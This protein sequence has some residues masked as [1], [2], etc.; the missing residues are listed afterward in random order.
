MKRDNLVFTLCGFL[1]G[2]VLGSFIIGPHLAQKKDESATMAA[3]IAPASS[4]PSPSA[5][6]AQPQGNAMEMVRQQIATLKQTIERNP[7]DADALV[8]LGNIYMDAAKY[9]QAIDYYE[10]SL[11]VREDGNVRTD[12][13]I[14][15]KQ[16]GDLAKSLAAFQK[17]AEDAPGQWQALFNEAIVLHEM[18]RNDEAKTVVARVE[19][20]HPNDPDVGKLR[21]ALQQ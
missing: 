2:L 1:L 3:D 20:L 19:Q 10:R 21:Q 4:A 18:H 13:G 15:Y 11:A 9:P 5:S 8:Q 17:A 6:G 7:R 14:C 12:L 16:A